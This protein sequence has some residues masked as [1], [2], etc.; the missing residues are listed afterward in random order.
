MAEGINLYLSHRPGLNVPQVNN[1]FLAQII[2]TPLTHTNFHQRRTYVEYE[3]EN[4]RKLAGAGALPTS[5]LA[6]D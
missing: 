1:K 5:D 3:I 2:L 6:E 4:G